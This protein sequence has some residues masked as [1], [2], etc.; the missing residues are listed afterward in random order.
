MDTQKIEELSYKE[1]QAKCAELDL[2][3][4]GSTEEL[5]NKLKEYYNEEDETQLD[6]NKEEEQPNASVA[7]VLDELGRVKRTYS[8]KQHGSSFIEKAKTYV[9]TRPGKDLEVETK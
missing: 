4:R 2:G 7:N 3:G 9:E 8:L 1:L 5:Q 6:E